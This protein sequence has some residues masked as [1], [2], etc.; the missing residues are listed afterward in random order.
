M[1]R[2]DTAM[3]RRVDDNLVILDI[4]T[5]QYFELN[6]VGALL[7]DRL[8][9]SNSVEDL[10][11]VVLAEYDIDRQTASTDV[12]DLLGEMIRAGLVVNDT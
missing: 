7:W 10:I 3:A 4:P 11:N 9:G 6:D 12:E 2:S 1:R 5:G 8:D